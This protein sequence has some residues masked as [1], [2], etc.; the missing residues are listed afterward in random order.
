[1]ERFVLQTT[2]S[3][4]ESIFSVKITSES[5]IKSTFNA[6]P[7]HLL[8]SIFQKSGNTT[9]ESCIWNPSV[10]TVDL[11]ELIPQKNTLRKMLTLPCII[12]ISGFYMW[13]KNIHE[14]LPFY[15]RV[16]SQNILGIPGFIS[17]AGTLR[18]KFTVFTR[19]ANV[20]LKPLDN[21][22]P[23]ILNTNHI[24]SWLQSDA[25][26]IASEGFRT[27]DFIPDMTVYRVPHLVN[28]LANNNS[29]LIQPIPKIKEFE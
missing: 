7:G 16:H 11:N 17:S 22:M 6:A 27:N 2:A 15:V 9:I 3:E 20:L 26:H 8:P 5:L 23:C 21:I 4:I 14:L 13:K 28:D 18:L 1:M 29:N 12:P 19:N 25:Y 24:A 10:P